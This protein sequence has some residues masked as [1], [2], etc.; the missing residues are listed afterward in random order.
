MT[1]QPHGLYERF[2]RG[3]LEYHSEVSGVQ[4]RWTTAVDRKGRGANSAKHNPR[5]L[6]MTMRWRP[7]PTR[8]E[9]FLTR[10]GRTKENTS[11][12]AEKPN[13]SRSSNRT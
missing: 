13:V 5:W 10:D 3:L 1:S 12:R 8:A 6:G 7:H 2:R 4:R 11:S 9:L